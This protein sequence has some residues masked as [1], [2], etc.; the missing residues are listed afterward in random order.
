MRSLYFDTE[1]S[2]LPQHRL[3]DDHPSQPHLVELA[4]LLVEDGREVSALH[5]VVRPDGWTIPDQAAAVHGITTER[6]RELGVPLVLALAGF[7]HLASRADELVAHNL[8]FDDRIL[9]YAVKR[10]G[11]TPQLALPSARVCTMEL[12][13]PVVN[14]PPT[15]KM[16]VAGIDGPKAPQLGEAYRFL[17]GEELV[18]AHGALADARACAR[19]HAEL[20][21]RASP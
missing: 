10:S 20:R 14:L 19:V 7:Y 1:T 8:A 9:R 17:F 4:A 11:R 5:V 3:P 18:G 13:K 2:G 16:L 12:A 6:A 21:R 15:P